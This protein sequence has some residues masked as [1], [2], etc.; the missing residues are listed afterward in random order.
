MRQT[1]NAGAGEFRSANDRRLHYPEGPDK[2]DY[3][4]Y[5]FL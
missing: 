4:A 1:R 2:I 5:I 3:R